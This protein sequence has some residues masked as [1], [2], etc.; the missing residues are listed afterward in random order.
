[1][2]PSSTLAI[3][4][5]GTQT[6]SMVRIDPEALVSHSTTRQPIFGR[7]YAEKIEDDLF[8]SRESLESW[9]IWANDGSPYLDC[10]NEDHPNVAGR[11]TARTKSISSVIWS[12]ARTAEENQKTLDGYDG[13]IVSQRECDRATR[14]FEKTML[15]TIK[16]TTKPNMAQPQD[17]QQY[18]A[19]PGRQRLR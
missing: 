4:F 5:V 2:S 14:D 3:E 12:S 10:K 6:T 7:W 11:M 16:A 15:D 13:T 9:M 19:P 17:A 18:P 8:D 1:V